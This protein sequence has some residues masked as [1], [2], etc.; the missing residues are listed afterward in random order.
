L[1]KYQNYAHVAPYLRIPDDANT[2]QHG[3]AVFGAAYRLQDENDWYDGTIGD[4][5]VKLN[6]AFEFSLTNEGGVVGGT[7]VNGVGPR[8]LDGK[9]TANPIYEASSNA[10]GGSVASM[11]EESLVTGIEKKIGDAIY[12][13]TDSQL[14][15]PGIV[16][17]SCTPRAT[18]CDGSVSDETVVVG[19]L[20]SPDSQ[21][22]GFVR[23]GL[24]GP[25]LSR[26]DPCRSI[27]SISHGVRSS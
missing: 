4:N 8:K 26:Y 14:V 3:G 7:D 16:A 25:P 23:D 20:D 17:T 11:L 21:C 2:E 1:L 15:Y 9:L 27:S 10:G 6:M 5:W 22:G 19:P 13:L 18:N 24:L 12:S